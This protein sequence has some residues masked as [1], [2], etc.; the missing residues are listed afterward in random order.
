[1]STAYHSHNQKDI[2]VIVKPAV[3][4]SLLT[5]QMAANY[6]TTS[7]YAN[8]VF[9]V[10]LSGFMPMKRMPNQAAIQAAMSI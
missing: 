7:D 1:M 5:N 3:P 8:R 10:E 4:E 2:F 6:F 9:L